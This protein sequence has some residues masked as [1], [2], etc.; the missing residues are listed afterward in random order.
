LVD[1]HG[2]DFEAKLAL[3]AGFCANAGICGV[4]QA[5]FK[6]SKGIFFGNL[7]CKKGQSPIFAARKE[8]SSLAQLVRA[9]RQGREGRWFKQRKKVETYSSLAQLVRASDC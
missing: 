4:V 8:N 1:G 9:S 2:A 3:L 6:T 5:D 7:F